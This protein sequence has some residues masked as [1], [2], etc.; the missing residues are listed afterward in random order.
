M[1]PTRCTTSPRPS[2]NARAP[3]GLRGL[4]VLMLAAA[5]VACSDDDN[6]GD[7]NT[8]AGGDGS[9]LWDSSVANDTDSGGG[10]GI[11][12]GGGGSDS[13]GVDAPA[14]GSFGAP[15]VTGFDCDSGF[16]IASAD[17]NICTDTCIQ[18]CPKDFECLEKQFGGGDT[19]FVCT[20]RFLN[21]CN[22]CMDNGDCNEPGETGALCLPVSGESGLIGK[23]C[24]APCNP[25]VGG[26][27]PDG[28][29]CS[30]VVDPD[31]GLQTEQCIRK[32]ELGICPCSQRAV[33][34]AA[35]TSCTTLNQYG[36][37][38]GSRFC[39]VDGLGACGALV[40][41][42]EQ[43]NAIDDDCNG[44]TDDFDVNS[45]CEKTNEFGTCEGQ[46]IACEEG[47]PICDAPAAAP[48]TCD[49]LDNNCDGIT[50][51][52]EICDDGNPCTTDTCNTSGT[53]KYAQLSGTDCD[54]GSICTSIDKCSQGTC[55]GGG[56][57]NCDDGDPCSTD[58]CDPFTGCLHTPSSDGFCADDGEPCTQD[59]C[60][61]G[62]CVH[63]PVA[64]GDPCADDGEQCTSDVCSNGVCTHP[65]KNGGACDDDGNPCTNDQCQDGL[66]KHIN[67]QDPCEDGN[68]CTKNDVCS[69]GQCKTGQF[70]TCD[71]GNPCTK[72]QCDPAIGCV[73]Q[74][75][76]FALCQS[77][78]SECPVGVCSGGGCFPKPNE[79]CKTEVGLDLCQSVEV[80]GTC[81]AGGD[82]VV[83]SAPPGFTCP[84]CNGICV[85]CFI[86]I[87]LP[88][89]AF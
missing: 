75:N 68:P 38:G 22:P 62:A 30:A 85:K 56:A 69:G 83:T 78:D 10:G 87:C 7:N 89:G 66:C 46:L 49:G 25:L 6:Q 54:D 2:A 40:P 79:P 23:F 33:E 31:S 60:Q 37:C 27:C 70:D 41:S 3:V 36:E 45:V 57:L 63:P 21:L 81:T 20:P 1:T 50:D 42:A 53:C 82:C 16:C 9:G 47:E 77:G 51:N 48:E 64:N 8:G 17:G 52:A 76:D 80:S 86:N 72:G 59:I 13:T 14:P 19:A 35:E 29:S 12:L 24:G 28:Y 11:D 67:N 73:Y 15:C 32:P 61:G 43:C 5:L 26:D 34:L 4:L 39:T 74:N 65:G 55:V 84:G 18:T 58:S 71:D 88:F 44:K